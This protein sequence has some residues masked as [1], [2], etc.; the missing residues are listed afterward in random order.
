MVPTGS[1]DV[2]VRFS[3]PVR[4][5]VLL[6]ALAALLV[7]IPRALQAIPAEAVGALLFYLLVLGLLIYGAVFILTYQIEIKNEKLVAEAV[8]NPF[9]P[10][11][12]CN[13]SEISRLDQESNCLQL[14]IY[15]FRETEPYRIL[16]MDL[17]QGGPIPML[18]AISRRVP[19]EKIFFRIPK[20]LRRLWKW[21]SCLEGSALL[22]SACLIAILM[23]DSGGLLAFLRIDWG[24]V[25][26]I[27]FTAALV[28]F[29]IDWIILTISNRNELK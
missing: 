29:A 14:L 22:L 27:F 1:T 21:Y 8:P 9:A 13:Y 23:I 4:V 5:A 11:F 25:K 3:L 24:I 17:F 26:I 10:A 12:Q 2:V 28:L 15:R 18:E 6:I 7:C 19:E 20:T 16:H